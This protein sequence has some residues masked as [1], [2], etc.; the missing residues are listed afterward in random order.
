V[1]V[2]GRHHS[3]NAAINGGVREELG[4]SV[5]EVGGRGSAPYIGAALPPWPKAAGAL[6]P[7]PAVGILPPCPTT[8]A[9]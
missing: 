4:R 2:S 6:A 9:T 8:V 7:W 3:M 5:G 1:C